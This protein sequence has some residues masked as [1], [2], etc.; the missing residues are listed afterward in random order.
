MLFCGLI[1]VPN[2]FCGLIFVPNLFCGL[3]FVQNLFCGMI[4]FSEKLI[5]LLFVF[6]LLI[7]IFRLKFRFAIL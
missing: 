6:D 4:D 3:L 1:F 5:W 2:L 7:M